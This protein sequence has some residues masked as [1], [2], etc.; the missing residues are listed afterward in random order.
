MKSI[1]KVTLALGILF[2]IALYSS[3]ASSPVMMI[4]VMMIEVVM[5]EVVMIEVEI[6]MEVWIMM[7]MMITTSMTMTTAPAPTFIEQ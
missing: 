2:F 1:C 7:M 4:E 6:Y 5:I 3:G